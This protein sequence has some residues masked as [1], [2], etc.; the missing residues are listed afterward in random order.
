[1]LRGAARHGAWVREEL[2]HSKMAA[3]GKLRVAV[4]GAGAAGLCAARH[5]AA[6]PESFAPPV[7]FEASGR[8]GGTWVYTEETGQEP[9]GL[10]VHSSMYR[11]LRT[12]LPKEVMA[13]PDFPFAPSLPSF[14]HHSDVLA[15]LESYADHFHLRQHVRLWWRVEA[16]CPAKGGWDLTAHWAQDRRVQAT[17]RFDAVFV[18]SGHYSEP[19]VPPI[20]G[21]ETFPGVLL[22]RVVHLADPDAVIRGFGAL[23]FPNC[24]GAIDGTH[25]PIRAPEHQASQYVNCKGYFSV[26]LQA[27]CDHQGQ[28]TDINV[29]WS[30][31]AHDTRVF[32]NSSVCQRLQA[33]TFFPDRHIRVG[34][35]DMPVCL[36]EDAAYPLQPWF[37]KPYT[38]HLNPSR[39][40][41]NAKLT[42]ARI[43]IEGGLRA[44]ESPLSMPPHPS[45]P[46][47]AQHPSRGGSMLCAT[48]FV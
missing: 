1:M 36:V 18:C 24:G 21:L 16:V 10:P 31:K 6:R 45:G 17:E 19:F 40:A 12:N 37:M 32:C 5:V 11:D 9:D 44:T 7:V 20:P 14:L 38:G 28:F 43:M 48:Q 8:I 27:V 46:G 26:I 34:D 25:I 15:Y 41:F 47:R 33:G 13:F 30:G 4:I 29:G 3:P 42:R 39:Q 2:L 23:G 22:H 35:M